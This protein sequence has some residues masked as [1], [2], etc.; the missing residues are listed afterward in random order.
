MRIVVC[1]LGY[2]GST[3]TA[4]LLGAG[5][6]VIGIDIDS[7]KVAETAAGRS[8]VF[9]PGVDE[10]LKEG[11][12]QGR[13][14]ADRS[15]E[16]YL[17]D[18]DMIMCCVGTP[19]LA[20]GGLNLAAVRHVA[21]EIGEGLRK[22]KRVGRPLLCVFR[23]TM[24]PG[25]MESVVLPTLAEAV[26]EP[27]GDRY[28]V[29]FNPEFMRESTAV[30]DYYHPAK[31]VIGEPAPG[32][33]ER[34]YGIYDGIEAPVFELPLRA[35]EMVK[36]CE[37][38]FHA[39]KVV[40][41]NEIGRLCIDLAID[42]QAVI[43]VF[44]SDHKLNISA[45]YL[46]PGGPFGGPCL[47]KDL[48]ALGALARQRGVDTAVIAAA[49]ASNAEHKTFITRRIT[50]VVPPGGRILLIG[51]AFKSLTDDLRESPLVELAEYLLGKGYDLKIYDPQL[52]DRD[53]IGANLRA[54][55]VRLPH[56]S[57]LL[58]RDAQQAGKIDLVVSGQQFDDVLKRLDQATPHL[59]LHRLSYDAL[60]D[61]LASG[62]EDNSTHLFPS[63]S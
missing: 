33:S 41:G 27:W 63:I 34:L 37:N 35:A 55:T 3:L 45:A 38:A 44:L 25:S 14:T 58:V 28:R 23:S 60:L 50:S 7:W 48:R 39:L 56:L 47:P 8:A 10:L 22:I 54:V 61:E 1:G 57:T 36:F 15:I 11:L 62:S 51:L 20:H 40:F 6:T 24:P 2:V 30:S 19:G 53:L 31:I 26:G 32:A 59:A 12:R 18:A 4:C 16:P 42:P 21:S 52:I 29:A 5:N 43:D 13:L 17:A 46:R 9:E 49:M